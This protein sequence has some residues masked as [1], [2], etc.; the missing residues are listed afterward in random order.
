M[1]KQIQFGFMILVTK[2]DLTYF[3]DIYRPMKYSQKSNKDAS[4]VP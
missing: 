2:R 3:M 4:W 1:P